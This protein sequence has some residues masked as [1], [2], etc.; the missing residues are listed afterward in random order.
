MIPIVL[1]QFILPLCTA[2]VLVY[3]FPNKQSTI[4]LELSVH[5]HG[6]SVHNSLYMNVNEWMDGLMG[7]WTNGLMDGWVDG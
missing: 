3:V 2:C 4:S 5:F 1:L 6:H 7:G